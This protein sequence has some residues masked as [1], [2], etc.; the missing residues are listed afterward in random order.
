MFCRVHYFIL[1]NFRSIKTS[2]KDMITLP[3]WEKLSTYWKDEMLVKILPI[4]KGEPR[5]M[6]GAMM[7]PF[8]FIPQYVRRFLCRMDLEGHLPAPGNYKIE[9]KVCFK[10]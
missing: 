8:T 4:M 7:D 2:V 3:A 9:L 1:P 6:C 10:G 5:I